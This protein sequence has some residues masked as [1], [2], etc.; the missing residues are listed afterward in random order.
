MF[1]HD[2]HSKSSGPGGGAWVR[3]FYAKAFKLQSKYAPRF[4][5]L[6]ENETAQ[7]FDSLTEEYKEWKRREETTVTAR[8]RLFYLYYL[9]SIRS[10]SSQTR[11]DL[12]YSSVQQCCSIHVGSATIWDQRQARSTHPFSP[13][14]RTRFEQTST[15]TKNRLNPRAQ[16]NSHISLINSSATLRKSYSWWP[17]CSVLMR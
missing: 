3:N 17:R 11:T 15:F 14:L 9:V 2:F 4:R 8:N 10:L 7:A 13:S 5:G 12:V 1:M 6:N 16:T